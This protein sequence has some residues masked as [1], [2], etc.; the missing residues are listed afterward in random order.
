MLSTVNIRFTKNQ[1]RIPSA[2]PPRHTTTSKAIYRNAPPYERSVSSRAITYEQRLL[3]RRIASQTSALAPNICWL[4][5]DLLLDL[6]RRL[7]CPSLSGQRQ[8]FAL[9]ESAEA[10][11]RVSLTLTLPTMPATAT[12]KCFCSRVKASPFSHRIFAQ[13]YLMRVFIFTA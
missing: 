1:L 11:S 12:R 8:S 13:T 5:H 2:K 4:I 6:S 7:S 3:N 10:S 9:I